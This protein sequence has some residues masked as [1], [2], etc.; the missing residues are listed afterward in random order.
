MKQELVLLIDESGSMR[1]KEQFIVDGVN[2]IISQTIMSKL[3]TEEISLSLKMFNHREYIKINKTNILNVNPINI[4]DISPCGQTA[5]L[6][7]L[8]KTLKHFIFNKITNPNMFDNCIIYVITDGI[9]NR[10]QKYNNQM[11]RNMINNAKNNYNI[12][13]VYIGS[14]EDTI[15]HANDI[16]I[17]ESHTMNFTEEPET[18][19]NMMQSVADSSSR[20]RAGEDFYFTMEERTYSQTTPIQENTPEQ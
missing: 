15:L 14:D 5:L 12:E 13:V 7:A 6:D 10:S 20:M 3:H 4:N 19:S 16:G 1:G 11:I 2:N 8:G 9:E 17:N 18:F